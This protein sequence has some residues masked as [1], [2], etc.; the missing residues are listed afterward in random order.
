MIRPAFCV[1]VSS[2][3][4]QIEYNSD[5]NFLHI[6]TSGVLTTES[7]SAMVKDVVEAAKPHG[8]DRQIVDHRETSFALSLFDYYE[9]PGVNR[10]IGMS[11]QWKIA[12]VF[13]ELNEDTHFMETVFR[14]RGYNFRQ[15]DDLEKAREW[16]LKDD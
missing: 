8:C 11:Y 6:K 1:I 15:F 7:A 16:V 10:Q 4:W 3:E 14:N 2:M 13:R 5:E 12:M 9:R